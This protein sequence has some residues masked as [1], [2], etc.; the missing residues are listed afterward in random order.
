MLNEI[1]DFKVRYKKRQPKNKKQKKENVKT[2]N[3][4]ETKVKP[5]N[6]KGVRKD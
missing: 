4:N 3:G 1:K 5:R 2:N 6:E